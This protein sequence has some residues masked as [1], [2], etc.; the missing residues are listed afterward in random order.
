MCKVFHQGE[1]RFKTQPKGKVAQS[2][3]NAKVSSE[4]AGNLAGQIKD[5]LTFLQEYE[6]EIKRLVDFPGVEGVELDFAIEQRDV[7]VQSDRFPPKL[8]LLC[9]QLGV[10]LTVSRYMQSAD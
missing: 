10:E 8:L 6:K 5:A 9:G 3:F 2:G 4:D 1:S 7:F